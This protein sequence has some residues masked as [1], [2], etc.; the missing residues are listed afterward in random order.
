MVCKIFVGS[1]MNVGI[2][3]ID[4]FG[5][6]CEVDLPG[7][8]AIKIVFTGISLTVRSASNIPIVSFVFYLYSNII[9]GKA[10]IGLEISVAG[11]D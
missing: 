9:T 4:P 5:T 11:D 3:P 10:F 8:T 2:I 6:M 7:V 1:G